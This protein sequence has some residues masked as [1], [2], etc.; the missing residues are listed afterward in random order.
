MRYNSELQFVEI[1]NGTIWENVAA[2]SGGINL[3]DATSLSI[4]NAIV[5]G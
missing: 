1:W 2:T 4:V 5:F 3:V